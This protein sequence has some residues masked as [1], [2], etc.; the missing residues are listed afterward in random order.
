M[1]GGHEERGAGKGATEGGRQW[2]VAVG[3]LPYT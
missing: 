3:V 2:G 1:S